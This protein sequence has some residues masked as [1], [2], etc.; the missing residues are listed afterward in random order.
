[1]FIFLLAGALLGLFS[2]ATIGLFV[3]A[4][5]ALIWMWS[6]LFV[7][8]A[9]FMIFPIVFATAGFFF[10]G[11]KGRQYAKTLSVSGSKYQAQQKKKAWLIAI[12]LPVLLILALIKYGV[13]RL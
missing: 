9:L 7:A 13:I 6:N 3:I 4:P 10:G 11:Y 12:G 2:G 8:L 5:L 1:M